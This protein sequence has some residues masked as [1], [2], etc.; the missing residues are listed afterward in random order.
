MKRDL[1]TWLKYIQ[2]LHPI[3]ID[4]GLERLNKVKER[5]NLKINCPVITVGGTNGKGSTCAY[6]ERIFLSAGYKTGLHTSPELLRFNE[7]ARINGVD[8]T[9]EKLINAFALIESARY[10]TTDEIT[11]TYFEYTTIAIVKLFS[12]LDLDV[13][14]LE[15]GL[16]GRLDSVNCI[17]SDCTVITSI[18]LDHMN[19]L[20]SSRETIGFEKAGIFRARKPAICADACPPESVVDY[21]EKIKTKLEIIGK[22]FQFF[23]NKETWTWR[24]SKRQICD[25]PY[26]TLYGLHQINNAS[27]AVAAIVSLQNFFEID[28]EDFRAGIL[29]A[30]I[31]G[32]F[33]VISKLPT[34]VLDVC[35]NPHAADALRDSLTRAGR[36]TKTYAIVG[37]MGD[38]DISG[39]L[40]KLLNLV[41]FWL[42]TALPT[43]RAAKPEVLAEEVSALTS[44]VERP[45]IVEQTESVADG[46]SML[47]EKLRDTDRLVVFGSFV[48]VAQFI[49]AINK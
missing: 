17:D 14:I 27:A 16:G 3:G 48:T 19:Y 10:D 37:M 7:R 45:V 47:K 26:P 25:I 5:L 24:S 9:D 38:K 34:V 39:T 23:A 22:D 42:C 46:Y 30:D 21:A 8:V 49:E 43:P 13:I 1:N 20:G 40:S 31:P 2:T 4:M 36:Y 32:R 44:N 41:D 18:D 29:T 6:L 28:D 11:L 35:H 12:E 15:V 33:Q